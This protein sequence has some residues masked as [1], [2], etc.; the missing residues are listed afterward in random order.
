MADRWLRTV[1]WLRNRSRAIVGTRSP[2]S[3]RRRISS[4]RW[5]SSRSAG[6]LHHISPEV[7]AS[8]IPAA[9]ISRAMRQ[10]WSSRRAARCS[11]DSVSR[12]TSS[13]H[14]ATAKRGGLWSHS[15]L[16][17]QRTGTHAALPEDASEEP[18]DEGPDS[19]RSE[20]HTSELQS[21]LHLVCRLLL[22]K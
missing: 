12:P 20:E 19:E 15:G 1:L 14:M 13:T 7:G 18:F 17:S 2:R 22:E 8:P 21:R 11:G 6:S 16:T 3:N 4:W 9:A 10:R 5:D